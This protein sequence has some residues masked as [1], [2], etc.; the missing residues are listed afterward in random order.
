[1]T[2]L[3]LSIEQNLLDLDAETLGKNGAKVIFIKVSSPYR[4]VA[5]ACFVDWNRP[6]RL[7]AV[8][9]SRSYF[10]AITRRRQAAIFKTC[11]K[12]AWK[13]SFKS[14][15]TN[16]HDSERGADRLHRALRT[17]SGI[18]AEQPARRRHPAMS[19][20]EERRNSRPLWPEY[21]IP[22]WHDIFGTRTAGV[23][24][25]AREKRLG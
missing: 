22:N 6:P 2:T 13:S 10:Y 16:A 8:E 24:G 18:D 14:E 4:A 12:R 19:R 17:L 1:M 3:P 11:S 21:D 7:F 23:V 25:A 9:V 20:G 15:R 5:G